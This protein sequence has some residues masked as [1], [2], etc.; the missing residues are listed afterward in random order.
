LYRRAQ[1]IRV[2]QALLRRDERSIDDHDVATCSKELIGQHGSSSTRVQP[3]LKAASTRP[4]V[5][6]HQPDFVETDHSGLEAVGF[7]STSKG[8]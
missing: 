4:L 8:S 6:E 5:I 2:S 3:V 1:E 7:K